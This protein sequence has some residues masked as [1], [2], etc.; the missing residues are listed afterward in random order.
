MN[1]EQI[2]QV[3]QVWL[4]LSKH[5]NSKHRLNVRENLN[6]KKL[7]SLDFLFGFQK[8]QIL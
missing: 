7:F 1:Y 5:N 6:V 8:S 3:K 2:G 4:S